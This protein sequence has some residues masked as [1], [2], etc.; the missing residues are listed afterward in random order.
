MTLELPR[1]P[2]SLLAALADHGT[3]VF[4]LDGTLYDTRDF[5]RPALAAVADWVRG[6]SGQPLEDL[7]QALWSRREA[8]RHR[9]GL[10]NDILL[11]RGLP[12]AW[13]RECAQRFHG[14]PGDELAGAESLLPQLQ[15]LAAGGCRLALVS[16]GYQSLQQRKLALLGMIDVFERCVYCDPGKPEQLKPSAWGWSELADWRSGDAAIFV[17]DDPVD[18]GFARSGAAGFVAFSFRSSSYED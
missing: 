4:D 1:D 10:F 17:G 15:A 8:D 3:I 2:Q 18:K 5:E 14:Y 9:P 12:E 11:E 16:N 13:G 6:R 7:A